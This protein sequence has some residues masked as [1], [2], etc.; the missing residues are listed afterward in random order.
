M[1]KEIEQKCETCKYWKGSDPHSPAFGNV[2]NC[3]WML[4]REKGFYENAKH[5]PPWAEGVTRT[6]VS[7]QGRDCFVWEYDKSG[8]GKKEVDN[9]MRKKK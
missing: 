6:M 7:W 9:L 4:K 3:T 8:K 2:K 1:K 5:I